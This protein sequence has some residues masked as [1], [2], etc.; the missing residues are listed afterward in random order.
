LPASQADVVMQLNVDRYCTS[1]D[2]I[3][4]T[5][6]LLL[7]CYVLLANFSMSVKLDLTAV[8]FV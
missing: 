1:M 7:L 8:A 5:T 3:F 4:T 6:N 2:T